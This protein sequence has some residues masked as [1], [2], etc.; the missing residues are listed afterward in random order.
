[1][2]LGIRGFNPVWAEFD[3]VGNIFDDTY[4]MFVLEN[5]LPYIPAIVYHDPEL[6]IP[7]TNPI[8]F[9]SNG[10]LPVD[11][12]WIPGHVYR[13]EFRKGP[14]Q[15]DPLIYLV[16]N[17]IAG[18]GRDT[19]IDDTSISSDNQI[20]NPQ[21]S[22]INFTS[23]Y[24]LSAT[25]PPPIEV[26]PGWFL[27]MSGTGTVTLERIALNNSNENPSNAPYA[28]RIN[29]N[30]W[31]TGSLFLRQRFEQNGML[32][33]NKTV[34]STI[35]T[36]IQGASQAISGFLID[37]NSTPLATV[38]NVP[39]VS[40]DFT[41]YTGHGT[42]DATTNPNLPPAAYIDYKI[43]LPSNIDIYVTSFQLI[44]QQVD[45][46][47]EHPFEQDSI[48]RQI[49]HTFN[50]YKNPLLNKQ[51][52][53]LLTGWDFPLNP[54]QFL[55]TGVVMNTTAAYIWDQTIGKSTVGNVVVTRNTITGGYQTTNAN[56]NESYLTLQYLSGAQAKK[57][58][59]TELSVNASAYR[60]NGSPVTVRVYLFR[61]SSSAVIPTL[62]NLIGSLGADGVFTKN[63]IAGQGLDWTEIPRASQGQA[64]G[65][66][67]FVIVSN[68]LNTIDDLKFSSWRIT[69]SAQINN[70]DKFAIIV[71]YQMSDPSVDV[72]TNS[73][74]VS[75]GSIPTRPAPQTF[76]QVLNECQYYYR[77]SF[78]NSIVPIQN[79]GLTSGVSF[80]KQPSA[81][82]SISIA[83]IFVN[84]SEE[85]IG[86]PNITLFN[87]SA[88]NALVRNITNGSNWNSS[89]TDNVSSNGFS[90][91][92]TYSSGAT[93][94]TIG[95]NWTADKRL[96]VF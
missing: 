44:V 34:S 75:P 85:M 82:E 80:G 74:A 81:F 11:I 7:W 69:D 58:L 72:I 63:N 12:Y 5:T 52:P 19:P 8:Q 94:S 32:W 77:K 57:I 48:N 49:D 83:G 42:L 26:G 45:D 20:T 10:T 53:S 9:L 88:N 4:Y 41:E 14:T 13:L 23:P 60:T 50:Y 3:L 79:A 90:V 25:N 65:T 87:P 56:A 22:I 27:E 51:I 47:S 36:R 84:F 59:G 39:S 31:S 37:S 18:P 89:T 21:F 17:Y 70:T 91:V 92:G 46:L 40:S 15:A 43:A 55:G 73:V 54:A 68:Q 71:T 86:T 33:A 95:I 29:A 16:E 93:N 1:M 96:G 62:P 78:I 6:S 28:L 64:I 2:T 67:P 61:G 38:L 30:G 35:T 24:T 76:S 66:L